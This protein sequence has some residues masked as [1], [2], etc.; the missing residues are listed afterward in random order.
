MTAISNSQ[1]TQQEFHWDD[2]V[3][4][5]F[6]GEEFHTKCPDKY[7]FKCVKKDGNHNGQIYVPGLNRLNGAY[8]NNNDDDGG[9]YFCEESEVSTWKTYIPAGGNHNEDM[10]YVWLIRIP[11]KDGSVFVKK[12]R[13]K[14]N[15][16]R[17]IT[18]WTV[19]EFLKGEDVKLWGHSLFRRDIWEDEEEERR[20]KMAKAPIVG[21]KRL[22]NVDTL[23]ENEKKRQEIGKEVFISHSFLGYKERSM[24]IGKISN[25]DLKR[26][27]LRET[28][29]SQIVL[30]G[31]TDGF[32]DV[33]FTATPKEKETILK[34][35]DIY[36]TPNVLVS[37]VTMTPNGSMDVKQYCIIAITKSYVRFLVVNSYHPIRLLLP[38]VEGKVTLT[39]VLSEYG[40]TLHE[41]LKYTYEV[42][43]TK[44]GLET[45][46][47]GMIQDFK[48]QD[49]VKLDKHFRDVSSEMLEKL[50]TFPNEQAERCIN[51]VL[52]PWVQ[53]NCPY[54]KIND[55]IE[56]RLDNVFQRIKSTICKLEPAKSQNIIPSIRVERN[57]VLGTVSSFVAELARRLSI[58]LG[59]EVDLYYET[60]GSI[61]G[62]DETLVFIRVNLKK[63]D[64]NPVAKVREVV[65]DKEDLVLDCIR[66]LVTRYKP[67]RS[68]DI[69]P[70]VCVRRTLLPH[71]IGDFI[72]FLERKL[73]D[74]IG[75]E[76]FVDYTYRGFVGTDSEFVIFTR[77]RLKNDDR[78]YLTSQQDVIQHINSLNLH[79]GQKSHTFMKKICIK[80]EPLG[81]FANQFPIHEIEAE[82]GAYY[83]IAIELVHHAEGTGSDRAVIITE[84]KIK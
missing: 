16:M 81:I 62:L 79:T 75:A 64:K 23:E 32:P 18:R 7:Y 29:R 30:A 83:K 58:Y 33:T 39:E 10:A 19:D 3:G 36:F 35:A 1:Q 51:E 63:E 80:V 70:S 25:T 60:I 17:L 48:N 68:Q 76:V 45:E 67:A 54:S 14:T 84:I 31:I 11:Y 37:T 13:F 46:I 59:A 56:E 21:I 50:K 44:P 73:N 9:M 26:I 49:K 72:A 24:V 47:N 52:L 69:V 12:G 43:M 2:F 66:D 61:G 38:I 74:H 22:R 65:V 15:M 27:A 71:A 55:V 78:I 34:N 82:V 28:A 5:S 53:N 57:V 42:A 41:C 20:S 6:T 77:V 40:K 4:A 8:K